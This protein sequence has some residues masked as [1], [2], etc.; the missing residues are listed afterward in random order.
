MFHSVMN[1]KHESTI[2]LLL[3]LFCNNLGRCDTYPNPQDV[4]KLFEVELAAVNLITN[5][6]PDFDGELFNK[7][8]Y[9][10]V[11]SLIIRYLYVNYPSL[12]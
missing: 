6:L 10:I 11:F 4:A 1:S 2:L 5:S 8:E 12:P 9:C 7:Y 3:L